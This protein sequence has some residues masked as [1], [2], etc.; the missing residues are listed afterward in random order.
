MRTYIE[1]F[2]IGASIEDAGDT[3]GGLVP[4]G[5]VRRHEDVACVPEGTSG[6]F[7]IKIALRYDLGQS[8]TRREYKHAA[9]A[10]ATIFHAC[11]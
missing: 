11:N 7:I 1:C 4:R 2:N 3:A 6:E 10:S 9:C 5:C 8:Q